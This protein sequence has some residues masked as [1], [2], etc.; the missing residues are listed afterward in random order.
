MCR[1]LCTRTSRKYLHSRIEF[2]RGKNAT[3]FYPVI[4]PIESQSV[5]FAATTSTFLTPLRLATSSSSATS[6]SSSR[7]S[8]RVYARTVRTG[9]TQSELK[10]KGGKVVYDDDAKGRI[11]IQE[12]AGEVFAIN[13]ACPHMGL[14]LEG[15]TPLLSATCTDRGGVACPVHGSEFDLKTGEPIGEWC[16]KLPTLPVV[17]KP[18]AGDKKRAE[19]YP[20]SILDDGEIAFDA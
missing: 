17:G 5:M 10:T 19:T 16:P 1:V 4:I 3:F 13:N 8:L 12:F 20:V 11:L 18:M 14:P 2:P 9:I 6:R 7:S 15:K